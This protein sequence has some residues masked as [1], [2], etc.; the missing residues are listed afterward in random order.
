MKDLSRD[1]AALTKLTEQSAALGNVRSSRRRKVP[2]FE[3]VRS[4]AASAFGTIQHSLCGPCN[5][6][7]QASICI[8]EAGNEHAAT[9]VTLR[10]VLHHSNKGQS[11]DVLSNVSF[12]PDSYKY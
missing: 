7:H 10:V 1:N 5:L 11:Q 2:N 3:L 12:E 8:K 4:Y 9:N 6:P